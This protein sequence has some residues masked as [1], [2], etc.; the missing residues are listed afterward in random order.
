VSETAEL[1]RRATYDDVLKL[2]ENMVGEIIDGELFVSPRPA[3][4][5]A[6]AAS[7]LTGKLE[8]TFGGGGEGPGGW[9]IIAEPEIHRGK[10][11]NEEI[12]VPDLAGWKRES[13]S[14]Y[15]DV[16]YFEIIP[17]WVCE[18]LSPSNM[19]LDR[20]KKVPLYAELGVRHLW[21]INPRDKML[22]TFRL[23]G[24]KWSLLSTYVE[25]G[26]VHA[27][28]FEAIELGLATL[29]G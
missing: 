23:E 22:E 8:P 27:E 9:W 15:P 21:L 6:L 12:Y 3:S 7:R 5:H 4:K 1:K 10:K 28:P 13:M 14:E 18:I 2:P 29:W 26:K 19:R 24:G 11:P 16:A 25:A 20:T 17:D